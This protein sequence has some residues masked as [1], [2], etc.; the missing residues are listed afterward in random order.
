LV[1]SGIGKVSAAA[2][3]QWLIDRT[4]PQVVINWGC[5]GGIDPQVQLGEIIASKWAVEYDYHSRSPRR[6]SADKGLLNTACLIE[7]I[8][9]GILVTADQN[10]DSIEKRRCLWQTYR[11]AACDWESAAVLKVAAANHIP[12][13]ALRVISDVEHWRSDAEFIAQANA[14]IVKATPVLLKYIGNRGI[15]HK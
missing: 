1:I 9:E 7:G 3:T 6:I 8:R 11:A 2:A 13:L 12:A 14:I 10:G 15:I 5:A 4:R